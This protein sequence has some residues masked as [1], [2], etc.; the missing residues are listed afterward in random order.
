MKKAEAVLN[1]IPPAW[2]KRSDAPD[3]E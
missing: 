3:M 1:R 2:G